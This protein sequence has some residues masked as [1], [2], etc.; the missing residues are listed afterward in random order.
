MSFPVFLICIILIGA[1]VVF[2]AIAV[3]IGKLRLKH[4]LRPVEYY[5]PRGYSPIDVQ[6]KYY[7]H[8]ADPHELFNPLMLYWAEKGFITIEEDCK[9]GLKL[10]KLKAIEPDARNN[11]EVC[12]QNYRAE[13]TLFDEMFGM[14]PVFYT[15]AAET[16]YKTIHE[17]FM[18]SCVA[19]SKKVNNS[20]SKKLSIATAVSSVAVLIA[21]TLICGLISRTPLCVAMI[22]PI[23]AVIAGK[24]MPD[25]FFLKYPFLAVWGGAPFGAVVAFSPTDCAVLLGCAVA[26]AVINV[27]ILSRFID[28]RS[29]GDIDVYG[30]ICA[31]KT[32]LLDAESDRLETLV[33]ENPSYFYDILPYCY[34]LKITDKLKAKF[35]KITLDGPSWYL[36]DMRDTLMF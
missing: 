27:H 21:I 30:Q 32:F 16:S 9:R 12:N 24:F 10:T 14:G 36:G 11:D 19:N 22:F 15:L 13:K 35:D 31:F 4:A 8:A 29:D 3:I 6:L 25:E 18:N 20:T 33:E 34:V 28:Y 26:A 7:S 23:V 2:T 1:T 5:P 17:K